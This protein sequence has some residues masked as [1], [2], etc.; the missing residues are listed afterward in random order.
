MKYSPVDGLIDLRD[1]DCIR[2]RSPLLVAH[3]GGVIASDAPENSLA[4][5]RLAAAHR[6]DMVELDVR[7]AKDGE[8]ALFHGSAGRGLLVD[9]GVERFLEDLTSAELGAIRYR[10]STECVATLSDALAL[11]ASLELGVMLDV[12]ADDCTEGYLRR[13]AGLLQEN[14]LGSATVTISHDPR[15]RECL[16]DVA[17]FPVPNRNFRRVLEGQAISLYGQFWFGWA[18]E[19]SDE[20]VATLQRNGAFIIVSINTF[21]YPAHARRSLARQDIVRL[22]AAG[23]EG[24]QIDSMY[25]DILL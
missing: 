22:R 17:I 3:R 6:Y 18:V 20:A 1:G 19:L 4:A 9:C 12:K 16:A 23:V 15:V 14:G 21:H 25:E 10:A 13:I 5:I 24:F 7:E 2:A 8:P 11:C